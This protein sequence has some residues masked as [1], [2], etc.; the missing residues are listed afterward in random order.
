MKSFKK[1]LSMIL[2]I[3]LVLSVCTFGSVS[4]SATDGYVKIMY[5]DCGRKYFSKDW[6]VALV[7]EAAYAG[8]TH[9]ELG[10]GNDG[11][12]FLLDD[13]A[14]EVEGTA[15]SHEDVCAGINAGNKAYYDNGD[16]NELTE[17]EMNE[18]IAAADFAGV[19]IIPLINTPGHMDAILDCM[20]YCGI[21]GSYNGSA[22]TVDVTN[23]AALAFTKAL[24]EKYMEYFSNMGCE[25]FNMGCD[26]YANDIYSSGGMGFGNLVSSGKYGSFVTYVNDI[27]AMSKSYGMQPMAFNDG[28]YYAENTS[29][30]TFDTDIIV[31][32]WSSGWGGSWGYNLASAS[33]IASKGHPMLNTHGDY[34][35]IL[36]VNDIFTPDT[37]TTH[38]P[39][40][41]T[42]ASGFENTTFMGGSTI[43]DPFG[44]K[45]CVWCDY[46]GAESQETVAANVRLAMRAMA[47]RM[48]GQSLDN[49]DTSVLATGFAEDGSINY[50][51]CTYGDWLTDTEPTCTE[52]GSMSRSCTVCGAVEKQSIEALEH[53]YSREVTAPTCTSQGYTTYTCTVCGDSLVTDYVETADHSYTTETVAP[54]CNNQGYTVYTCTVC[55]DVQYSEQT[56]ALGHNYE[57]TVTPPTCT[58]QGYTYYHCTE[59]DSSYVDDATDPLGHSFGEWSITTEATCTSDGE[60]SRECTVCGETETAVVPATD[61]SYGEWETVEPTCSDSGS[62]TKICSDCSDT[63]FEEL[64]ATGHSY[65]DT[66][67]EPTPDSQ[68]YTVHTYANCGDIYT[69]SY[70]QYVPKAIISVSSGYGGAGKTVILKVSIEDNPGIAAFILGFDYDTEALTLTDIEIDEAIGGTTAVYTNAVWLSESDV[71]FS[72]EFI[73][74]TFT[75]NENAANGDYT[76]GI[77]CKEGD[78]VNNAEENI[79]FVTQSGVI[80]VSDHIPGDINDDGLVNSADLVRFQKYLAEIEGTVVNMSAVDVNNDGSVNN[81][82]LVYLMRYL[83]G[84]DLVLY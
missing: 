3:C 66:V 32:Y 16:V 17:S 75:V 74:L 41:Y 35:Y 39:S 78:I 22:R 81:K 29:Y 84:E 11:L 57:A 62:R 1:I 65:S 2:S 4:T 82:D 53:S 61:H 60:A 64:A 38:T 5:V 10:V 28:I 25:Y 6:L 58:E 69:D 52:E 68:G 36:G 59:C 23:T 27:A 45:F 37:T 9:V 42:Q 71:A 31:S 44:S 72:G 19:G 12:R 54:D 50:H 47:L 51:E 18:I 83:S 79:N 30:G 80:T 73:T 21:S 70:T 46:P 33:F 63:V 77:T 26:E 15:Y 56:E 7:N 55:G 20:E 24:L 13:M 76:V 8:Y 14:L 67:V 49:M 48:D 43:S 40:N 34:Y